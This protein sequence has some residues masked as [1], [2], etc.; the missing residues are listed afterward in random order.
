MDD[1]NVGV[2]MRR[3][4]MDVFALVRIML[5][6][7]QSIFL[8]CKKKFV[9]VKGK[10]KVAPGEF[11]NK[12]LKI[13]QLGLDGGGERKDDKLPVHHVHPGHPG[14]GR[15]VQHPLYPLQGLSPLL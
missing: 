13:N 6:S 8:T 3:K 12:N 7:F 2:S 5:T 4:N 15:G 10:L 9:F 11:S 1:I 14:A